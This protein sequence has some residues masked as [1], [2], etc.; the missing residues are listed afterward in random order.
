MGLNILL[1]LMRYYCSIGIGIDIGDSAIWPHGP[2][3]IATLRVVT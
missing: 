1:K 2:Y 3:Y